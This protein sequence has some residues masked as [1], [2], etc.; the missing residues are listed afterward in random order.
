MT[1]KTILDHIVE[2]A[3][4]QPKTIYYRIEHAM[5]VSVEEICSEPEY[6]ARYVM[7]YF[8]PALGVVTNVT[9]A[10]IQLA[11]QI[12]AYLT[13]HDSDMKSIESRLE[14]LQDDRDRPRGQPSAEERQLLEQL[15][16]QR[17]RCSSPYAL[18][19]GI[20]YAERFLAVYS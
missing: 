4:S 9:E 20:R 12:L 3:E 5:P 19:D 1:T 2:D 17:N 18:P 15:Q 7:H 16:R 10:D 11:R 13:A 6:A 14:T 8:A